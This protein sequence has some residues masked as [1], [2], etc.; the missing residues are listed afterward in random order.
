M[1]IQQQTITGLG[2]VSF[3]P[4]QRIELDLWRV[5]QEPV[6]Q[7]GKQEREPASTGQAGQD[8]PFGGSWLLESSSGVGHHQRSLQ[9]ISEVVERKTASVRLHFSPRV[10]RAPTRSVG[11]KLKPA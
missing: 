3:L 2:G 1:L 7:E 10:A 8:V 5:S 6:W 9:K 11:D 4:V